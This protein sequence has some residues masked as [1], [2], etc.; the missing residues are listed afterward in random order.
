MSHRGV[1]S[2][3][4][5][6]PAWRCRMMFSIRDNQVKRQASDTTRWWCWD[7]LRSSLSAVRPTDN[8]RRRRS[9]SNKDSKH[10][11]IVFRLNVGDCVC[12]LFDSYLIDLIWSHLQWHC[13]SSHAFTAIPTLIELPYPS[14]PWHKHQQQPS[15]HGFPAD[16][17]TPDM[18]WITGW[19]MEGVSI[20]CFTIGVP[21]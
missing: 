13:T 15:P 8:H 2:N 12:N 10:Y 21:V 7:S 19:I 6:T 16:T 20:I 18:A 9:I 1:A 5:P 11:M 17:L 14:L 3:S 4:R